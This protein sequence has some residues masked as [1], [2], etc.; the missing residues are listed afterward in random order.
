MSS[1]LN[2]ANIWASK[3]NNLSRDS[4]AGRSRLC[5]ETE[6]YFD[7]T[8]SK[9]TKRKRWETGQIWGV[10]ESQ[11]DGLIFQIGNQKLIQ[12]RVYRVSWSGWREQ[13]QAEP[14]R[15][16]CSGPDVRKF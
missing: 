11:T 12:H 1:V 3:Q 2:L 13:R 15:G 10:H 16:H 8:E 6:E 4:E 7:L 9:G 5:M 14:L